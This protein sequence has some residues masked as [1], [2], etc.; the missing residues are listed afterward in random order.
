M[1]IAISDRKPISLMNLK[2][3]LVYYSCNN[4]QSCIP[5]QVKVVQPFGSYKLFATVLALESASQNLGLQSTVQMILGEVTIYSET[6]H[7]NEKEREVTDSRSRV[8][9]QRN[10][11]K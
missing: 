3:S 6:R 8:Y 10:C 1:L 5:Q 11:C 2:I 7:D 4:I 9:T